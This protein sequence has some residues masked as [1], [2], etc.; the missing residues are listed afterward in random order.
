[1]KDDAALERREAQTG[2]QELAHDDRGDHPGGNNV[3][4]DQ[5]HEHRKDEDLVRDGIEERSER[6]RPSA[7][8]CDP[9]VEPVGRHRDTEHGGR[10]VV[11]P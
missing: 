6:R 8:P 1:M 7:T 3:A 10:P 4:S 5:H 9:S 2:D 11:V